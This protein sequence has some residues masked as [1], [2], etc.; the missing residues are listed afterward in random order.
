M[1][2]YVIAMKT[3]MIKISSSKKTVMGPF[4]LNVEQTVY[5]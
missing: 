2:F 3:I 5:I 4:F 1:L